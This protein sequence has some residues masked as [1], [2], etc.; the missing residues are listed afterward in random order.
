M[1]L[2]YSSSDSDISMPVES[3]L[4]LS[5]FSNENITMK[6]K[7]SILRI[8]AACQNS[9]KNLLLERKKYMYFCSTECC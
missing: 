1:F 9:C 8:G 5:V 6:S 3:D 7:M 2:H 4:F